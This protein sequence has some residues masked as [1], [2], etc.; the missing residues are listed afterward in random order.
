[1]NSTY[2]INAVN[3]VNQVDNWLSFCENL[4]Y[5]DEG[6]AANRIC[7]PEDPE[8]LPHVAGAGA[9]VYGVEY[10]E[11]FNG[12]T[13][14]EDAPCAVCSTQKSLVVMIPAR[15]HCHQ[16]WTLEYSGFGISCK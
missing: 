5:Q 9:F 12:N 16:G 8:Y 10:E 6:G 15:K 2:A 7:M 11:N 1:M 13:I 4:W 14:Q 3:V